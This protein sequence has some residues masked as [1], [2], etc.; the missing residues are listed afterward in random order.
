MM[1]QIDQT[2]SSSSAH[3]LQ[4]AFDEADSTPLS[5]DEIKAIRRLSKAMASNGR[6][7]NKIAQLQEEID[8]DNPS[9]FKVIDSIAKLLSK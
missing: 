9:N 6:S 8:R 4:L 5:A 7:E 3:V 1:N 2:Q